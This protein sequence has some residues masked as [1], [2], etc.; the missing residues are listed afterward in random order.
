MRL[1]LFF[2]GLH[3]P[4]ESYRFPRSMMSVNVLMKRQSRIQP[5]DWI[6]DSGAFTRISGGNDHLPI[7]EY[8]SEIRRWSVCGNLVVA[9]SQDYMC[10]PFV[11][12]VTGMTVKQH[13]RLT[14]ERYEDLIQY[15]LPTTIMPV[16]QG[17]EPSDYQRHIE[18][19]A[20]LLEHGAWVGVG[21]IC[22][23][24]ANPMLVRA[25]LE[26][27]QVERPDLRLHGFGIKR[28]ALGI[29]SINRMLYSC[30]SMAWSF[31]ARYEGRNSNDPE[32]ALKYEHRLLGRAIQLEMFGNTK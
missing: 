1:P 17:F 20:D 5:Q 22:K 4:K 21:S 14:I 8:V 9:V 26:A 28:T 18:Q 32:E 6:M 15:D 16:L 29:A 10:E 11:L 19:Y 25:V 24:N 3:I 30:D 13:Q 23:R 31:A 2:V 12:N 27:I 7:S